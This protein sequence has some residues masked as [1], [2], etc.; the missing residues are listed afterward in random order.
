M[1]QLNFPVSRGGESIHYPIFARLGSH[2]IPP[3]EPALK[4]VSA[5]L[6][7]YQETVFP[8]QALTLDHGGY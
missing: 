3:T 1:R 5:D 2:E 4:K 8:N 6:D 7:G